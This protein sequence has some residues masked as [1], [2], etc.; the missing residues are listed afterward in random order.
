V[1][2][3]GL[4]G[5]STYSV[6][7]GAINSK[8]TYRVTVN[9]VEGRTFDVRCTTDVYDSLPNVTSYEYDVTTTD[10]YFNADTLSLAAEAYDS[11]DTLTAQLIRVGVGHWQSSFASNEDSLLVSLNPLGGLQLNPFRLT[12]ADKSRACILAQIQLVAVALR[13]YFFQ[14]LQS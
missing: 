10:T 9:G 7:L 1:E 13:R 4:V 6:D 11:Y 12:K 3:G 14:V 8:T 5:I 2:C